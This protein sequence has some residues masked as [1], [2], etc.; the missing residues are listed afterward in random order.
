MRMLFVMLLALLS[1]PA[2][3][4]EVEQPPFV[5]K[6]GRVI[7][8]IPYNEQK[9]VIDSTR[10]FDGC[11]RYPNDGTIE[12]RDFFK[13]GDQVLD[14]F[15]PLQWEENS[16]CPRDGWVRFIYTAK[17]NLRDIRKEDVAAECPSPKTVQV[18]KIVTVKAQPKDEP[19]LPRIALWSDSILS[20]FVF[21][22][23]IENAPKEE[24][25]NVSRDAGG[26]DPE[27]EHVPVPRVR[28]K[29][30]GPQ[31]PRASEL[32]IAPDQSNGSSTWR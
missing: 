3:G 29:K 17:E 9:K 15:E 18:E 30:P 20:G 12:A 6:G 16:D 8:D 26:E 19:K 10:V 11:F 23:D 14:Y 13:K 32:K 27:M 7:H 28:P 5:T 1:T 2:I 31:L 24:P 25:V 21:T 22:P 4:Q